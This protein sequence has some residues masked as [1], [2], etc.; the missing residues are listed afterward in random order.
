MNLVAVA[1]V[2][3]PAVVLMRTIEA[4]AGGAGVVVSPKPKLDVPVTYVS[5]ISESLM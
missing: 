1:A 3:P 4:T 2:E 5:V